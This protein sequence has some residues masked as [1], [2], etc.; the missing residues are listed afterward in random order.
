VT[1]E[2]GKEAGQVCL[3]RVVRPGAASGAAD[4]A[5]QQLARA[6]ERE[7]WPRGDHP[8]SGR[9][10]GHRHIRRQA[11]HA[12]GHQQCPRQQPAPPAAARVLGSVMVS[13]II[14]YTG[15][16]SVRTSA[17]TA[18]LMELPIGAVGV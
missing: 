14:S 7:Q 8:P 10:L 2:L 6:N 13:N 5:H 16:H 4:L 1:F 9:W 17:E 15:P 12:A 3:R 11:R 18:P